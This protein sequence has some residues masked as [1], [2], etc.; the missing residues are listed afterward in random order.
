MKNTSK[1]NHYQ[2]PNRA[3]LELK[4]FKKL[5]KMKSCGACLFPPICTPTWRNVYLRF[6]LFENC[7]EN[8]QVDSYRQ[9]S[10]SPDRFD[11]DLGRPGKRKVSEIAHLFQTSDVRR[12]KSDV[13]CDGDSSNKTRRFLNGDREHQ[14]N[15]AMNSVNNVKA[16]SLLACEGEWNIFQT[17]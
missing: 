5:G 15:G 6:L 2:L 13:F 7:V 1:F 12:S 3:Y 16:P 11:L 17:T 10:L 4:R 8:T 14:T 9:Q